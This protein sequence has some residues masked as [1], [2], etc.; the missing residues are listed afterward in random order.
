M[1]KKLSELTDEKLNL[2]ELMNAKELKDV[3]GGTCSS[4][5]VICTTEYAVCEGQNS[6]CTSGM[7]ACT[8]GAGGCIGG[9]RV[10]CSGQIGGAGGGCLGGARPCWS[11]RAIEI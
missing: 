4:S 11:N 10:E 3:H 1:K 8:G 7:G 6:V 2:G 5:T 9:V